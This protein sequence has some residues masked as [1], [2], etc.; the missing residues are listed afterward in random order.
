[1]TTPNLVK[2]EPY[3]HGALREALIEAAVGLARDGGPDAVV[4]R[5]VARRV[6]VSPNAAY[7]HFTDLPDLM[8]AV[9]DAALGL[10]AQSMER[11]L[12]ASME[13]T[14][15][16]TESL[17]YLLAAGRGYVHFALAEPGLFAAAF[18]RSKNEIGNF[19]GQSKSGM[20]AAGFL[21]RAL[22]G[23]IAAGLMAA[24]D[25]E[26]AQTYAWAAVHGLSTLLLGPLGAVPAEDH[27]K[28][29]EMTL[30]LVCRGLLKR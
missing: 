11:E 16:A 6:G 14:D 17:N 30:D 24:E 28:I 8:N 26:A 5:E 29:I 25:R 19:G 20:T 27:E 9:C 23:L 10:L 22:D 1:V 12:P 18:A 13:A 7:R 2:R 15:P 4:L 21:L 3:H